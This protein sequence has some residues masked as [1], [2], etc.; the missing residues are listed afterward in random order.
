MRTC[1]SSASEGLGPWWGQAGQERVGAC[2]RARA[3][4]RA[5]ASARWRAGWTSQRS[6]VRESSR[7]RWLTSR[8]GSDSGAYLLPHP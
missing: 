5:G 6:P 3:G 1:W 7:S 8:C 2:E 4:A